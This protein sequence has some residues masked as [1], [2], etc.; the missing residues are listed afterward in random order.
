MP[1][2]RIGRMRFWCTAE[3]PGPPRAAHA[4][5]AIS[6]FA[7]GAKAI[8]AALVL[9]ALMMFGP[10]GSLAGWMD[11]DE[12]LDLKDTSGPTKSSSD[13]KSNSSYD[14]DFQFTFNLPVRYTS[15]VVGISTDTLQEAAP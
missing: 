11:K 12:P 8:L 14:K 2:L 1:D 6:R 7:P 10:T 15:S 5:R 3:S 9:T 13:D 4:R